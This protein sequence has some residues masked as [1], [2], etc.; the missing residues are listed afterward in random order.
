MT[1]LPV[2]LS[3][4]SGTRLWPLSRDDHP[5]QFHC[6][7]GKHSLY[8]ATVVRA[9]Q[10]KGAQRIAVICN[11]QHRFTAAQQAQS[12]THL[13]VDIMLEPV[14]R[15]TAPAIA[16]IAQL[17]LAEDPV[18]VVLS[19]DHYLPDTAAFVQSV[20][21]AVTLAEQGYLVTFGIKPTSPETGYGYIEAGERIPA[22]LGASVVARF[23]EKPSI[24]AATELIKN[25]RYTWN[26]GMFVMRASVYL[27]ELALHAPQV[28]EACVQSVTQA[29]SSPD[30]FRLEPT[31]FAACP[32]ISVDYAVFEHSQYVATLAYDGVWSD[33]GTWGSVAQLVQ[34]LP[35]S[36][37]P[38]KVDVVEVAASNNYVLANKPVVL[39]GVSGVSVVDTPDALLVV[40]HTHAQSVKDAVGMLKPEHPHLLESH[41][42][43]QRPWGWYDVIDAESGFQ[44]KQIMVNPGASLSLQSHEHRAEHW[45]V[46]AGTATIT[47]G[48]TVAEFAS[49]SHVYIPL[50]AKHRLQN[51]THQLVRLV[52]VQC[53]SYL[54]EDDIV[55]YEDRYNRVTPPVKA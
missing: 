38:N 6:L 46:V 41:R 1:V 49:N 17:H 5:K 22:S 28:H 18:L 2:I 37:N 9:S 26:S 52:E 4:G 8:E 44:V 27:R 45:V 31:H 55:R 19:A 32:S 43:V 15:N 50:K 7:F 11:E 35:K 16:A 47:V 40:S 34:L 53:G 21:K 30:F 25:P 36:E 13:P 3:G 39:V 12:S 48:D 42:K 33:L 29:L 10:V 20:T 24:A 51:N 23:I 14:G 54:G